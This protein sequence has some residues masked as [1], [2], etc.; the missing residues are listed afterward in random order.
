MIHLPLN[1]EQS[2]KLW[3]LLNEAIKRDDRD[4]ETWLE[5]RDRLE[6]AAKQKM[7]MTK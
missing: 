3:H 2:N 4:S 5:L 7:G 1:I 6:A